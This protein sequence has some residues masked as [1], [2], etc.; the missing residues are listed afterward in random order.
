M[1]MFIVVNKDLR[2]SIKFVKPNGEELSAAF[3]QHP[4]EYNGGVALQLDTV[5][6]FPDQESSRGVD[7]NVYTAEDFSKSLQEF[8]ES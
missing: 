2:A 7:Q 3:N 8:L 4:S 5:M 1:K 6:L